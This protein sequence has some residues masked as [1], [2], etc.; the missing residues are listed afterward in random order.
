MIK[1]SDR[2]TL[3]HSGL[4]VSPL[5]LGTMTFGNKNWGSPDDVSRAIF[6]AYIDA[7]GNFVDTADVYSGGRSEELVGSFIGERN[8]RDQVVL[9][10]KFSFN[11]G[12][13]RKNLHRAVE[14][15][16]R[17]LNTDYIDLYWV[18]VWDA[19]TPAGELLQSMG[20]LVRSGKIRYFGLSDVPAWY[21]ARMA[22]LAQTHLVPG[23]IALQLVYSLAERVIEQE[24]IPA[25][26]ELGMGVT[27]WSPLGAGFL[28]GKYVRDTDGKPSTGGGRLDSANQPFR[29]FTE[30][31]WKILDVLRDVSR[32][33]DRPMSQVALAW[34]SSQPG[35]TSLIVGASKLEQLESNIQSLQ[36]TLSDADQQQLRQVSAF[37]PANFYS[38]FGDQVNRG[39][40][41]GAKVDD[42][43]TQQR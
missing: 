24:H 25:A 26:R 31:N 43:L 3:G 17:R 28:S 19:V 6:D 7:G 23:P 5:S 27:P 8:L 10:T 11:G 38:L 9:A 12:N 37:D 21:A 42:W 1:L 13:G 39:I 29:M 16:L 33:I 22:T 41:K 2:R 40:F 18:H 34:A 36:L 4:P 32:Q 15:S 14:G 30:R 20:D 35:I